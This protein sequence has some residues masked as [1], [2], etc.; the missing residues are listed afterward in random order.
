[1]RKHW[2]LGALAA[3]A[4]GVAAIVILT[5]AG[6]KPAR[7][8]LLL[9]SIDT[10][11]PDHLGAYGYAQARTPTIDKLAREG[12]TFED[13]ITSVPLTLPSHSSMLTGLSPLAHG[14]RDNANFRLA[15]E[16]VTLA[17]VLRANS[18][19]TGAAVGAFIL[20]RRYGLNQGFTYYDDDMSRG[21]QPSS[22]GY[23]ERTADRVTASA[24]EWLKTAHEPFM[25]FLHYYDPHAPY[26]PPA[27]FQNVA[28]GNPYDGE[29]AFTDQELGKVIAYLAAQHLLKRTLVILTADHGEGFGEHGE[30]THGLLLYNGTLRVPLII[31]VPEASRLARVAGKAVR[32]TFQQQPARTID[33]YPTALEILGYK[34]MTDVDGRSLVPML[35]GKTLPPVVSYFESMASYFSYRWCPLRGVRFNE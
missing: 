4:V 26:Q 25:L 2:R 22:F 32:G 28:G 14:I 24:L 30:Q 9:V 6:R 3:V 21:R 29:I 7:L 19:T 13:V 31:R 11:R 5:F 35:E 33:I 15:D 34:Q 23:P 1:M 16:F 8:N 20:D 18:Y 27:G 12:V 10:L 17:E